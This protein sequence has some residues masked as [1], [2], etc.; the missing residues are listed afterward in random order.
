M[1]EM[2][3]AAPGQ[4]RAP[5]RGPA[6]LSQKALDPSLAEAAVASL[7]L[8]GF[9]QHRWHTQGTASQCLLGPHGSRWSGKR[10][11]VPAAATCD[12]RLQP[13]SWAHGCC[14]FLQD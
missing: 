4:R 7:R 11:G 13:S 12:I 2:G 1:T 9:L 3:P 10:P 5:S 14:G 6:G 8:C